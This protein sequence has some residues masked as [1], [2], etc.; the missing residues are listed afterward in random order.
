MNPPL[1]LPLVFSMFGRQHFHWLLLACFML[2]S[3]GMPWSL[4]AG[5]LHCAELCVCIIPRRETAGTLIRT[6]KSDAG[7]R[8]LCLRLGGRLALALAAFL[9][10]VHHQAEQ[11]L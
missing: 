8:C 5:L 10:V 6:N 3:S 9:G 2:L 11:L 7:S 1:T 4:R